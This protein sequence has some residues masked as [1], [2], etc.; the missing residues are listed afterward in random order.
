[1]SS[2]SLELHKQNLAALAQRRLETLKKR[3]SYNSS[4]VLKYKPFIDE[5]KET[6]E[7]V[8]IKYEWFAPSKP[9]TVYKGLTDAIRWLMLNADAGL[10]GNDE[11][12]KL[13]R[14]EYMVYRSK[15]VIDKTTDPEGIILRHV[16]KSS[17]RGL[18]AIGGSQAVKEL[19]SQSRNLSWKDALIEWI[20]QP[21]KDANGNTIHRDPIMF[22]KR[23]LVLTEGDMNYV[24]NLCSEA[25]VT[26]IVNETT[27][28]AM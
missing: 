28:K 18:S 22:V 24:R 20:G 21:T 19:E 15:L 11:E 14:H 5:S 12:I 9:A 16:E 7:D 8:V 1:M 17:A 13:A 23:G 26:S 10:N 27:I 6:K 25:G 4:S 2:N 3:S